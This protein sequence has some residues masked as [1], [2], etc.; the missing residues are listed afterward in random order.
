[1]LLAYFAHVLVCSLLLLIKLVHELID[2]LVENL[3]Q[4][5]KFDLYLFPL[6]LIDVYLRQLFSKQLQLNFV[7]I[8]VLPPI[9]GTKSCSSFRPE[10]NKVEQLQLP[11]KVEFRMRKV[12]F[13]KE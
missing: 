11:G 6:L 13:P 3:G 5:L 10:F 7:E 2:I 12:E 4:V 9:G 8:G 1:M